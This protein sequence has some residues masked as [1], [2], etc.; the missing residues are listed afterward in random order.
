MDS[1]LWKIV[2]FDSKFENL[3][4]ILKVHSNFWCRCVYNLS[5]CL[6]FH[7]QTLQTDFKTQIFRCVWAKFQIP[8]LRSVMFATQ[9]FQVG[10]HSQL[11]SRLGFNF[12][13]FSGRFSISTFLQ[14]GFQLQLFQAGF[15]LATMVFGKEHSITRLT[16]HQ[17]RKDP[18]AC[19]ERE[20]DWNRKK[21]GCEEEFYLRANSICFGGAHQ[22]LVNLNT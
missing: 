10:F 12:N 3:L 4:K 8:P 9:L 22:I 11:F 19:F 13:F 17:R 6:K 18:I 20:N 15:Q 21:V 7:F 16:W 14:A 5:L 2:V 1:P